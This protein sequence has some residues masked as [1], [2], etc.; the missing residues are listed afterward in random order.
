MDIP[1]ILLS[2]NDPEKQVLSHVC[3]ANATVYGLA[4]PSLGYLFANKA[5]EG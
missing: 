5:L 3:S 4:S 1:A 2:G